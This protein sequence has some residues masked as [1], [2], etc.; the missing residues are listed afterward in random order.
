MPIATLINPWE[1]KK[2]YAIGGAATTGDFSYTSLLKIKLNLSNI[3]DLGIRE[4]TLGNPT[5]AHSETYRN[6]IY[7]SAQGIKSDAHA[8]I[9]EA[10]LNDFR[11]ST[12]LGVIG[13]KSLETY[14]GALNLTIDMAKSKAPNSKIIVLTAYGNTDYLCQGRWNIPNDL[15]LNLKDYNKATKLSA[16]AKGCTVIDMSALLPFNPMHEEKGEGPIHTFDGVILNNLGSRKYSDVLEYRMRFIGHSLRRMVYI[17]IDDRPCNNERV[18]AAARAMGIELLMPH[19]DLIINRLDNQPT[20]LFDNRYFKSN[21]MV[22]FLESFSYDTDV[23]GYILSLDQILSGGLIY[24]RTNMGDF[25]N[26]SNEKRNLEKILGTSTTNGFVGDK[27]VYLMDTVM[28]LASTVGKDGY[29]IEIYNATRTYGS[30]ER[31]SYTAFDDIIFNYGRGKGMTSSQTIPYTGLTTAQR[32]EYL[33][34]RRRKFKLIDMVLSNLNTNKNKSKMFYMCGVD[35][36]HSPK[37]IQTNEINYIKTKFNGFEGRIFAGTDEL[38]TC[39]LSR[40]ATIEYGPYTA[41]AARPTIKPVYYGPNRYQQ[42]DTFDYQSL[43]TVV[44]NHI[45]LCRGVV[46]ESAGNIECLILTSNATEIDVTNLYNRMNSNINSHKQTIVINASGNNNLS[47]NSKL[48]KLNNKN[49]ARMLSYSSWNTAANMLGLALGHGIG[50]YIFM[51]LG[52]KGDTNKAATEAQ[53]LLL[54]QELAKDIVYKGATGS[55]LNKY[56]SDYLGLTGQALDTITGNFYNH[57]NPTNTEK[58]AI[59]FLEREME[60]KNYLN[61]YDLRECFLQNHIYDNYSLASGNQTREI[62]WVNIP[63]ESATRTYIFPWHRTFEIT[64]PCKVS[65]K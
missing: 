65:F 10:G 57:K 22:N 42:A 21:H 59:G 15:N 29:N 31:Q 37:T 61:L 1:N 5:S 60:N 11:T 25:N 12:K 34:A 47:L 28:R 23:K 45:E 6:G 41:I 46:N 7:H 43:D 51:N 35:D 54:F 55:R 3:V 62:S 24:S 49:T 58:V 38:A 4:A 9:I 64:V 39:L 30:V 19:D 33:N 20:S 56:L 2:I 48:I 53:T 8:V 63:S 40:F 50:R 13:D 14:Y 16:Q 32:D 27:A 44:N 36:S 52:P 17:P 18:I 26:L